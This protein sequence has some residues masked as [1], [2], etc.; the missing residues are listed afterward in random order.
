[1]DCGNCGAQLDRLAEPTYPELTDDDSIE[2]VTTCD[3]CGA[4]LGIVTEAVDMTTL[5][6]IPEQ[7]REMVER[8]DAVPTPPREYVERVV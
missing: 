5:G 7:P 1:M 6:V 4:L 3:G 8:D 2:L